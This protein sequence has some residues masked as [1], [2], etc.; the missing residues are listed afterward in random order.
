MPIDNNKL[1]KVWDTLRSGG[2]TQDYKTFV[3]GFSGDSNY[4][5]RKKVYD[6][7]TENGAQIGKDYGEFM[8]KLHTDT[9]NLE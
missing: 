3:K 1:K 7:L 4:E 8:S 5:N 6:L 2:Y 9:P